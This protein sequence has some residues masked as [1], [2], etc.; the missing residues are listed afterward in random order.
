MR[1]IALLK[2]VSRGTGCPP[3]VAVQ[4]AFGRSHCTARQG[5]RFMR[6]W[7]RRLRPNFPRRLTCWRRAQAL[8][9]RLAHAE[10]G[11]GAGEEERERRYQKY[12]HAFLARC[13]ER[14][15]QKGF[16]PS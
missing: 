9:V 5:A 6:R 1:R 10:R 3:R 11:A 12:E 4:E 8:R 15:V 2:S 16:L 14:A 13:F 7:G